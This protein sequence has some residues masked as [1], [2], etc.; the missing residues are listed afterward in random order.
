MRGAGRLPG[1]RRRRS[2][3]ESWRCHWHG[4]RKEW[5]ADREQRAAL[6]D[7]R[8]LTAATRGDLL[9][10][11]EA[12]SAARARVGPFCRVA[13][14][15]NQPAVVMSDPR[16]GIVHLDHDVPVGFVDRDLDPA[17]AAVR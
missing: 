2:A 13:F 6:V 4:F 11:R 16:A 15:E 3:F 17:W 1:N 8:D 9:H 14:G 7:D 10:E 5:Q 12:E